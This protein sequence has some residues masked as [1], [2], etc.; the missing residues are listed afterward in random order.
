MNPTSIRRAAR[1][2]VNVTSAIAAHHW[3]DQYAQGGPDGKD[4]LEKGQPGANGRARCLRHVRSYTLT[5]AASQLAANTAMGI[6]THPVVFVG[7]HVSTGVLHYVMDRSRDSGRLV[8]L[9]SRLPGMPDKVE[10]FDRGGQ[11]ALDQSW[12]WVCLMTW[13]VADARASERRAE[14]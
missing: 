11:A 3:G 1:L 10:Y 8:A 6:R 4:P 13:A 2:A 12:H 9:L 5:H 14:R 7:G